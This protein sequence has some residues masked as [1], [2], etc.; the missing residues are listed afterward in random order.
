MVEHPLLAVH[1]EEGG[2]LEGDNPPWEP[3][4]N[5]DGTRKDM[6]TTFEVVV[7]GDRGFGGTR[8]VKD[9]DPDNSVVIE[10][11]SG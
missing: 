11:L 6:S 8:L 9:M 3:A 7:Y 5:A 10:P 1:L 2:N 4:F